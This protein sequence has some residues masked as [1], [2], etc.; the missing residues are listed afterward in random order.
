MGSFSTEVRMEYLR[1]AELEARARQFPA[2]YVPFGPIEWHGLHL[3]LGTDALKAQGVVVKCAENYGG[4]VYPPIW[5]HSDFKQEYLVPLLTE[6]FDR[7]KKMGFR[8][9]MGVS[10]HNI[11]R[12]IAMITHALEPVLADNTIRGV[13]LWEMSLSRCEQSDTDHAAKWETSNM[14]YLY[15][16]TVRMSELGD[17]EMVLDMS[18][19]WG[20]GGLDPRKH[21]SAEVGRRNID[22]A[23]DAIGRKAQELLLSLPEGER[24]FRCKAVRPEYWWI[25]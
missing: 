17:G 18:P 3:P 21:A 4:V 10:G 14:L 7:L 24:H 9:I 11:E 6:L 5:F 15:P 16:E 8:V 2:V 23:A 12:Q 13:G 25:V 19:P 22:L 1:P 20:I